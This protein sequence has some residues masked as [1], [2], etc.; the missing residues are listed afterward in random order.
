MGRTSA[1]VFL[2]ACLTGAAVAAPTTGHIR[3]RVT[4]PDGKPLE[5]VTVTLVGS[6]TSGRPTT[7]DEHGE[8]SFFHLDPGHYTVWADEHGPR[9]AWRGVGVRVGRTSKVT[10]T[11]R[12]ASSKDE[13]DLFAPELEGGVCEEPPAVAPDPTPRAGAAWLCLPSARG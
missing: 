11:V 7:T 9:V 6:A 13:H 5:N 8:F 1:A 2:L 3:G 10:I 4:D 12:T